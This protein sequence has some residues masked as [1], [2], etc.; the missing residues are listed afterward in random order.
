MPILHSKTDRERDTA[1]C[2]LTEYPLRV[3]DLEYVGRR[4]VEHRDAINIT[5]GHRRVVR[6]VAEGPVLEGA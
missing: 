1:S 4:V 6:V 2:I 5:R 3:E